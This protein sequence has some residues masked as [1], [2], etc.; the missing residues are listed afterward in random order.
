[1]LIFNNRKQNFLLFILIATNCIF[2]TLQAQKLKPLA[3]LVETTKSTKNFTAIKPF[4]ILD[5]SDSLPPPFHKNYV[6]KETIVQIKPADLQKLNATSSGALNM[7]L[8][9]NDQLLELELVE[10]KNLWENFQVKTSSSNNQ[11]ISYQKAKFYKGIVKGDDESAVSLSIFPNEVM[12]LI[13]SK[14][15]G[16]V[17][18]SK[19]KSDATDNSYVIYSEKDLLITA[20]YE[21]HTPESTLHEVAPTLSTRSLNELSSKWVHLYFECDYALYQKKGSVENTVNYLTGIFNNVA[22]MYMNEGISM[23]ISEVFVW[24]TPSPYSTTSAITAL[25]QF[26]TL[27][28]KIN[29]DLGHLVTYGGTA[30][31][32]LATIGTPCSEFL[33]YARS[34]ISDIYS[35][36][37]T[38]SWTTMVITHE[39]GHN[40]G[41][42]HTQWCGWVG[43]PLDNCFNTEGGCPVGPAPTNGG[44]IMSYC[45]T[46]SY[47]INL[48][49]GFGK[50]PGDVIRNTVVNATCLTTTAVCETP[51]L[52]SVAAITY[53]SAT[54]NCGTIN[55]ATGY[56]FEF[57]KATD[58]AWTLKSCPTPN[59][60]L[61]QLN[62]STDYKIRVSSVCSNISSRL[63]TE[64]AFSTLNPPPCI[65]TEAPK[66]NTLNNGSATI[67]WVSVS[68]ATQYILEYRLLNT[69]TWSSVKTTSLTSTLKLTK[70]KTYE[71][72]V[73]P[74][75]NG[76][77][78]ITSPVFNLTVTNL[79]IQVTT[80]TTKSTR[81]SI[82]PNPTK[83]L[84]KLDIQSQEESN[85]QISVF[86]GTGKMLQKEPLQPVSKGI[87]T[88]DIDLSQ[89]NNGLYFIQII[90]AGEINVEKV[91]L[92][93]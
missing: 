92:V 58:T 20:G 81:N 8:P 76:V 88:F 49:N 9:F 83:G 2:N 82:S 31:G 50:Q 1:M 22:T 4:S 11:P 27:R 25:N 84:V 74:V 5:E 42:N 44:T 70:G 57:K 23:A 10:Q 53:N 16:N 93:H 3:Q 30:T 34:N 21:C 91:M 43:G 48:A 38:Y 72:R 60:P 40:L 55:G 63:S 71:I 86:D 33:R 12:G 51:Q 69:T 77:Q 90:Q 17:V 47:G 45:H 73:S 78:G 89:Y 6:K 41:S 18:V 62:Y 66:L 56:N 26:K 35:D 28:P 15:L 54:V 39:I 61:S 65:I 79:T 36:F 46:K 75:C 67:G 29:G 85:V 13:F 87:Q 59:M 80:I 68:G 37:P 24:T 32:G 19:A 7:S 52:I 64:T 14:T